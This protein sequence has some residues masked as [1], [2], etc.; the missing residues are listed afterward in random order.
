MIYDELIQII[1]N[2]GVHFQ[3]KEFSLKALVKLIQDEETVEVIYKEPA[4]ELG[5]EIIW[6]LTKNYLVRMHDLIT[7]FT[8]GIERYDRTS[9]SKIEINYKP[10]EFAYSCDF[11]FNSFTI[12]LNDVENI[13]FEKPKNF[14]K[15]DIDQYKKFIKEFGVE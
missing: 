11:N 6:F 14:I 10:T 1:K 3:Y 5:Q 8:V 12:W 7:N 2:Q 4:V 13:T 15:G 9:I